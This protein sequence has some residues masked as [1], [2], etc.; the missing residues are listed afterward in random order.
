MSDEDF[1]L[2][3]CEPPASAEGTV[4]L[5]DDDAALRSALRNVLDMRG[6]DV[7]EADCRK[8]ALEVLGKKEHIG[9]IILDL[10]MPP[11]VHSTEEGLAV[12]RA[13]SELMHPAKIIV[14]T[15]QDEEQSALEA[16]REG[17]FDFLSKPARAEDI[18]QAVKRAFLF[19]RNDQ[20]MAA[21]GMTRLQLNAKVADGLKA[22]REEAEEKLVR[23]VLKD[24]GF[25][26]YQSA[27]RLGLK[28]ES[29]Y[30]FLKKFEIKRDDS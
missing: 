4:L 18:V 6:Y 14:L 21:E 30:Y 1:K 27:A 2:M 28:R 26:V 11:A 25:N 24:T 16:I 29:I 12:I 19:H 13:T 17:A 7:L 22:V 3:P 9:V 5:V 20:A 23:Q 8:S 10:G 15:G